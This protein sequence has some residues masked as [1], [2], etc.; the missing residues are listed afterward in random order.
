MDVPMTEEQIRS[1][2]HRLW[3]EAGSP[4][5]RPLHVEPLQVRRSTAHAVT[6]TAID[7]SATSFP[8]PL[9]CTIGT[10]ATRIRHEYDGRP[11]FDFP[12]IV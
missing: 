4:D 7:Q 11:R 12:G 6:E 10:K 1:L 5:R 8:M 3:E 9:W 2:A